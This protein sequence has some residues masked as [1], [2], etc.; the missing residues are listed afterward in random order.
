MRLQASV[1]TECCDNNQCGNGVPSTCDAKCAIEY[2]QYYTECA[3]QIAASFPAQQQYDFANLRQTC[4]SLPLQ[5]LLHVAATA[6]C[7][8]GTPPPP[9]ISVHDGPHPPPPYQHTG[10]CSG[11]ADPRDDYDCTLAVDTSRC[12]DLVIDRPELGTGT[13]LSPVTYSTSGHSALGH[14][15]H[16]AETIALIECV[17][18]FQP[19]KM[20][21]HSAMP[22]VCKHGEWSDE[23][24]AV[25]T[26]VD[27]GH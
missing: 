22:M 10:P 12:V 5:P 18:G 2:L 21:S 15:S 9:Q 17:P 13:H 24:G 1:N 3:T 25:I 23:T 11:N 4:L 27:I 7:D 16:A 6:R 19:S 20:H 14:A 26:C 8:H